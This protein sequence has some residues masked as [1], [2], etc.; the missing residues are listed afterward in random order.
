MNSSQF[1]LQGIEELTAKFASITSDVKYKGGRFA[2]RKA[3]NV[4]AKAAKQGAQRVDDPRTGRS[5]SDNV[6]VRFSTRTFK[7]NGNLMF[8]VGVKHGA[9]LKNGGDTSPNAPTPHW[10]LIEFGTEK[11]AADPF[12]RTALESN[13][14]QAT[15]E[16]INQ[17]KKSIDRA[18]KKASKATV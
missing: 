16:F 6:A 12:M 13:V 17:Y 3:A 14:G 10:R 7:R 15:N 5:I 8:R 4:V 1:G 11:M 9:L 2:L 18:I